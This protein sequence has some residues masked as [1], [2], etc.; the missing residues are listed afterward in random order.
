MMRL[1]MM[2]MMMRQM[3]VEVGVVHWEQS[4]EAIPGDPLCDGEIVEDWI[5]ITQYGST[6]YIGMAVVVQ[7]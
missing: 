2:M 7:H 3:V 5:G 1:Q 4:G 6:G